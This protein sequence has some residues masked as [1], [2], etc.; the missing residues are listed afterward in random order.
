MVK[1]IK[2]DCAAAKYVDDTMVLRRLGEEA[3]AAHGIT[4][5]QIKRDHLNPDEIAVEKLA[6][7]PYQQWIHFKD[8]SDAAQVRGSKRWEVWR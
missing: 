8:G 7:G 1:P 2:A 3:A 6:Q 4:R 5:E